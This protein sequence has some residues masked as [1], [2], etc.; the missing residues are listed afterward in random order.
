MMSLETFQ[1]DN[2]NNLLNYEEVSLTKGEQYSE[3]SVY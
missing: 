2:Q 1:L 3:K